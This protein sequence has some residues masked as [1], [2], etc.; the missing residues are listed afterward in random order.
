MDWRP[1]RGTQLG[2][3]QARVIREGLCREEIGSLDQGQPAMTCVMAGHS[4]SRQDGTE[5]SYQ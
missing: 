1:T 2:S 4:M 3:V 5:Q